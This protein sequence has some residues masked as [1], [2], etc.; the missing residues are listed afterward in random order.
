[1][2][3]R[4]TNVQN[5]LRATLLAVLAGAVG[6]F[7]VL[8]GS[9][10][11]REPAPAAAQPVGTAPASADLGALA[12]ELALWRREVLGAL[13]APAERAAPDAEARQP[14]AQAGGE[15][16]ERQLE[17]VLQG[18]ARLGPGAGSEVAAIVAAR[19][20]HPEP[21]STAVAALFEELRADASRTPA[22]W[23]LASMAEVLERLGS[24]SKILSGTKNPRM[25]DWEYFLSSEQ[26]VV[27]RFLDGLVVLVY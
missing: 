6:G 21:Q 25:Q 24:P 23:Q 19:Q 26:E 22:K 20:R 4:R 3:Q 14:V 8:A 13:R 17:A 27:V 11:V 10:V 12:A 18:L 7:V 1:M 16:L 2:M 9:T 15:A 5:G